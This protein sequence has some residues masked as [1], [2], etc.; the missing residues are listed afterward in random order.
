MTKTWVC[1]YHFLL[2]NW[3]IF[4]NHYISLK[5][6]TQLG[7]KVFQ[8]G[9]RWKYLTILNLLLQTIFFGV[10][11]LDDV[12]K[13]ITGRKTIKLVTAFRDLLFTTLAFPA[14]AFIFL[15]FWSIFLYNREL[16]YPKAIEGIFPAWLNHA[17]HTTILPFSLGEI[18]LRPYHYPSR[19][20][21]LTLLAA[22]GLAYIGRVL[23]LYF[24]TGTWVYPVF[25]QLSP[26]GL[27]VFFSLSYVLLAA[28]YLLGEKLNQWKWGY[29]DAEPRTQVPQEE[30]TS[31]QETADSERD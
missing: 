11:C 10:A 1:I 31:L 3:Y 17:M 12:L 28:V 24:E 7:S 18:I 14:S 25:A 16:I 23:W 30:K 2:F 21:G 20:T 27:A 26:F 6:K 5:S 4:I 9:G 29:K 13:R 8:D 22:A 15:A 19:K